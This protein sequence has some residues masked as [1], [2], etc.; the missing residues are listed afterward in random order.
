MKAIIAITAL[1]ML[2]GCG[3]KS[4]TTEDKVLYGTFAGLLAVDAL[5]TRYVYEHDEYEELNLIIRTYFDGKDESTLYMIGA[6]IL[7]GVTA[8]IMPQKYRTPF[9]YGVNVLEAAVVIRNDSIG[10]GMEF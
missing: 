9:L 6:G 5:Q 7:V 10:I 2:S 1:L 4:W 8:D 3:A